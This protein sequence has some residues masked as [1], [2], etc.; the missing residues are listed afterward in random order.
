MREVSLAP[1]HSLR[2]VPACL[3]VG[4]GTTSVV[5]LAGEILKN[6]KVFVEDNVHPQVR[7]GVREWPA[8]QHAAL[9]SPKHMSLFFLQIYNQ[10]YFVF[11]YQMFQVLVRGLRKVAVLSVTKIREIAVHVKKDD[12]K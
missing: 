1:I 12:D 5:L 7:K 4:D 8:L 11:L 3:Q 6:C 9:V 10:N 2:N